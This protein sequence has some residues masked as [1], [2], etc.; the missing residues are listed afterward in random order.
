VRGSR[1]RRDRH[2]PEVSTNRNAL[3]TL[4]WVFGV[5]AILDRIAA[6]MLGNW[7]RGEQHWD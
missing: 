5:Y 2:R 3:L 4:V 1:P 6:V 7:T